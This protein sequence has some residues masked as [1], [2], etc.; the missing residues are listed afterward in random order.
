VQQIWPHS[1]QFLEQYFND[2]GLLEHLNETS[3]ANLLS[4]DE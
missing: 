2:V 1:S 3:I 4:L